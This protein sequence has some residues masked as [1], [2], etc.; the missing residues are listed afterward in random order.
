MTSKKY[1]AVKR[2]TMR[3]VMLIMLR[4]GFFRLTTAE[5]TAN[6][7][8]TGVAKIKIIQAAGYF[9]PSGSRRITIFNVMR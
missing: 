7:T 8:T 4:A 1:T 2:E 9:I 6:K 5:P 3:A